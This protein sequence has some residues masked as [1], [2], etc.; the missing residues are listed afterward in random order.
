MAQPLHLFLRQQVECPVLL[1]LLERL[2][3]MNAALDRLEVRH[4]AAEPAL[5]DIEHI[6]TQSLLA[7]RLLRLFLRSDEENRLAFLRN[8][9]EKVIRLVHLAHRLLQI[10]DID[11][12]ALREDVAR[13]LRVPAARLMSEMDACLQKL[14][15]RN[16]CH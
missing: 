1:H 2:E 16:H 9:A 14:L 3:A 11:T 7:D 13:H 6:C 8:A 5:I 12:V 4:H 15:H 10:D